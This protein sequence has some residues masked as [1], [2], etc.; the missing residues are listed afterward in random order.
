V[1]HAEDQ[2]LVAVAGLG[3]HRRSLFCKAFGTN[4]HLVIRS[5]FNADGKIAVRIGNGLPAEFL[6]GRAANTQLGSGQRET[7]LS[8]NGTENQKV[9]GVARSGL[10][11]LLLK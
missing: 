8:E 3:V 7:F 10:V 6:L 2:I 11:R 1:F 9:G 4:Q 5:H